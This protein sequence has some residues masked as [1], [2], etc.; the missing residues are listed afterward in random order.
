VAYSTG[1]RGLSRT[2]AP[3]AAGKKQRP[4]CGVGRTTDVEHC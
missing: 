1:C 3:Q 2:H 4:W